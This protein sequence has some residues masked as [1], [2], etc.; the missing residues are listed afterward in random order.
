M[1]ASS[2]K[3]KVFRVCYSYYYIIKIRFTIYDSIYDNNNDS[4]RRDL[5]AFLCTL[6]LLLFWR[7]IGVQPLSPFLHLRG[8]ICNKRTSR[9]NSK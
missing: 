9:M 7:T 4:K 8:F 1:F 5:V 2:M 3:E 6:I